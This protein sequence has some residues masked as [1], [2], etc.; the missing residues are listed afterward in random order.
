ML[1]RSDHPLAAKLDELALLTYGNQTI[2]INLRSNFPLLGCYELLRVRRA[3]IHSSLLP[4]EFMMPYKVMHV[5]PKVYFADNRFTAT[6]EGQNFDFI[7]GYFKHH[8]REIIEGAV[9]IYTDGS[10]SA[11]ANFVG[12]AVSRTLPE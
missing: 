7:Q 3:A 2:S 8:F 11:N 4:L 9:V 6:I 12:S 1:S 5:K 10:K